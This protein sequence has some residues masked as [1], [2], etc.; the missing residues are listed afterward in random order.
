LNADGEKLLMKKVVVTD[1]EFDHYD[2][3]RTVAEDYGAE[4]IEAHTL[5]ESEVL[6]LTKGAD[7][8]VAGYAPITAEVLANLAS[9]A[10]VV[11]YA[12][13]FETV[14]V[15]AATRLGVRVC[16][17]PDYGAGTVAD[18]TVALALTLLRRI[19]QY[20][21]ALTASERGW[22]LA[23]EMGPLRAMS[24][25]T[26]GLIG[27][28]QIGSLVAERMQAFG[29]RVV[30]CDPWADPAKLAEKNIEAV[31]LNQLL[32]EAD[33]I[34]LHC[35]LTPQTHHILDEPALRRA[36]PGAILINTARGA[37]IDTNAAARLVNEGHLG[38]LGLD[39]F[40]SEPLESDHPLRSAT[41]TVLTPHAAFY[42][43]QSIT[44]MKRLS[45]DEIARALAGQPLRKQLN[46]EVS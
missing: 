10:T 11:R 41:N 40:E 30:A 29:A 1:H 39:V 28:G 19:P 6:E 5:D 16:N 42:S 35:P 21:S 2:E 25:I 4:Y 7:V 34:S 12:I 44:N 9:R 31:E 32:S 20:H 23:R 46:P 43:T 8:V 36:K 38:G 24:E 13:G 3:A 15:E 45:A 37:L 33:V 17:V 18:H 22:M 27:T 14:D 26:V